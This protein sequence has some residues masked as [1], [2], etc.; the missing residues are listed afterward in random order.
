M[1]HNKEQSEQT[2]KVLFLFLLTGFGQIVGNLAFEAV[3]FCY[4]KMEGYNSYYQ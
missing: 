1:D 4:Y 3:D 2:Q